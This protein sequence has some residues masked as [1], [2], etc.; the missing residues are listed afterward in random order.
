[1]SLGMDI[2]RRISEGSMS[3]AAPPEYV[4]AVRRRI[5]ENTEELIEVGARIRP[6]MA[7]GA[8]AGWV[9]GVHPQERKMLKRWVKE[10]NDYILNTLLLATS[11]S[12]EEVEAFSADEVRGLSEVVRQM[13]DCDMSLYPFLP[14]YVTTQ[15]SENLWYSRG[16]ALTSYENKVVAMPDGRSVRVMAPPNHARMW[17]SLCQ[18]REQAKARLE[19]DFNALFIVRPWAGKS[20]DPVASE[21]KAAARALDTD[22][23]APWEKVVRPD[24]AVDRDDGWGHPGDSVE[25]LRR[26]LKGMIEGDKHERLMDAW[27]KQ[28]LAEAEDRKRKIEALRRAKGAGPGVTERT[29]VLTEA[30][31]RVRQAAMRAGKPVLPGAVPR[32]EQHEIDGGDA[33]LDKVARYR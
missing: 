29:E 15:S 22:S 20:A 11:L 33:Q 23:L 26:E 17:A 4:E 21:L 32:R 19:Q 28:M 2:M 6:L 14:A 18:Y 31:V 27:Q 1:M 16:E 12:R 25:D 10:P 9:R 3:R 24:P 30:E 5:T 8:K 13:T 7:G